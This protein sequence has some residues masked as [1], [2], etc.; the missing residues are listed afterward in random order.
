[1]DKGYET[2]LNK[3]RRMFSMVDIFHFNSQNTAD[4][5][6][7]YIDV[8]QGSKVVSITH[9]S[10]KDCRKLRTNVDSIL[11]LGFIG[12]EAPYKG[13]PLLKRV[14][15]RLNADG[16]SEKLH[17]SV[18]GGRDGVDEALNNVEYK[19]RFGAAQMFSIYDSM[20]LLIVPSICCETFGFST[21][22]ALQLGVPALV[23]NKVGAKDIVKKY[24]PQFIF[25]TE[26][27]LYSIL[28]RL[29]SDKTELAAYNR[30]VVS[31]EWEWDLENHSEE[32]I[33]KIYIDE[34]K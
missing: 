33:R 15:G 9:G 32:I 17:L 5:Y 27:E 12:S 26:D 21:I 28:S 31:A 14:I 11:K 22:E 7:K 19:G 16:F 3:Y 25:N 18:Y 23:S 8:P 30:A 4:V 13:L 20:D 1:M 34:K 6:M 10:I 24:A 2:L 29:I